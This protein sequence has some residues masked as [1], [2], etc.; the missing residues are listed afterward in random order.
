MVSEQSPAGRINGVNL[1]DVINKIA[2]AGKKCSKQE[3]KIFL[4]V[5]SCVLDYPNYVE[6][7]K[8]MLDKKQ[9]T[10]PD[11]EEGNFNI[12]YNAMRSGKVIFSDQLI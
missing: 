4:Y 11:S 6:Y 9:I 5:G 10:L 3:G 8:M 12:G 2:S 7:A 1:L